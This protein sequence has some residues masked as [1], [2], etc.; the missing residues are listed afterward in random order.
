[1][2]A[3]TRYTSGGTGLGGVSVAT[4]WAEGGGVEDVVSDKFT[5]LSLATSVLKKKKNSLEKH[6]KLLILGTCN[7]KKVTII[8]EQNDFQVQQ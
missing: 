8:C 3:A 7:P 4:V 2:M 1:M 6:T 5:R